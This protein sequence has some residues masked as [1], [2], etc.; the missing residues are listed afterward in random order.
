[1]CYIVY[2]Y[3]YACVCTFLWSWI[4]VYHFFPMKIED[5]SPQTVEQKSQGTPWKFGRCE[6]IHHTWPHSIQPLISS[7]IG[8]NSNPTYPG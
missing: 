8:S 3:V 2:I 7:S 4:H 1:M 5:L 6:A